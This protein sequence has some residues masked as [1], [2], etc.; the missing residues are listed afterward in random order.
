MNRTNIYALIDP[1]TNVV[2]YI[3]KSN[4][5]IRRLKDHISDWRS[6]EKDRLLWLRGLKEK[7]LKPILEIIEE[8]DMNVWKD[9]EVHWISYYR[10]IG[11]LLNVK[12][13]G[14]GLSV[15]NCTSFKRN[16]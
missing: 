8:V 4:D 13:G 9:R 10:S 6:A 7:G 14:Q 11:G 16:L 2:K 1:I 12:N 5:P 3:G 15:A